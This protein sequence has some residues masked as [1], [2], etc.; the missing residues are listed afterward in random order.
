MSEGLPP[1]EKPEPVPAPESAEQTGETDA[2]PDASPDEDTEGTEEGTRSGRRATIM[3]VA[4][5]VVVLV[6]I[7]VG[8][9][10]VAMSGEEDVAADPAPPKITGVSPSQPPSSEPL[11]SRPVSSP[12]A[13]KT[14]PRPADR[15]V[16]AARTAAEQAATAI[17]ER[18]VKAMKQLSCDP[19]TVGSVEA[20]PPEATARLAENPQISGDKATAQIELSISGSEP[21]VVPLP[22]EKRGGKWCV[23]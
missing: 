10:L 9:Y 23:P 2:S 12:P 15:N 8:I 6:A 14:P 22:M 21:T 19:S 20:F 3:I 17:N 11:P 4:A 16:A 5:A 7:G 13:T 1:E 18:D